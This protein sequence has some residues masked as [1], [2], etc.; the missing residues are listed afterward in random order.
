MLDAMFLMFQW[1]FQ[2]NYELYYSI[3]IA[4]APDTSM[5]SNATDQGAQDAYAIIAEMLTFIN[6]WS[7]LKP[8]LQFLYDW[9]NTQ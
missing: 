3:F 1:R 8:F 9:L 5:C 2:Q 6:E 4:P 7:N